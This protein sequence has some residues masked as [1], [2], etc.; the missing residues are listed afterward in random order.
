[1]SG[2]VQDEWYDP[3]SGITASQVTSNVVDL[4]DAV[5][6]T[7]SWY[8]T[9]GTT[10]VV[11]MQI[12]NSP[13]RPMLG[14]TPAAASWVNYATFGTGSPAV[15]VGDIGVR[16]VRFLRLPSGASVTLDLNKVFG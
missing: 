12:S 8:T 2:H 15:I 10:S 5:A 14:E 9:S 7:A 3:Y 6:W 11:T 13:A 1:M 16:M 4:R